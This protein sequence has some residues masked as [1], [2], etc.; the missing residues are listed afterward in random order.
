[1]DKDSVS[2]THHV[3]LSDNVIRCIVER[4]KQLHLSGSWPDCIELVDKYQ[5]HNIYG[6]HG[7]GAVQAQALIATSKT[8]AW[9]A[10][11]RRMQQ[12]TDSEQG[13][14]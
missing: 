5:V 6:A 9:H 10:K 3:V 12:S 1:M 4:A 14:S 7:R 13:N 2:H 8:F 11:T